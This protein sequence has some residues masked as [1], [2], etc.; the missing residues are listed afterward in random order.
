M[1]G[2]ELDPARRKAALDVAKQ[3]PGLLAV[4]CAP[5][6]IIVVVGWMVGGAGLGILLIAAFAALGAYGLS[7]LMRRR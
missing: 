6:A 2:N 4:L 1:A 3:H 7:R 5:A